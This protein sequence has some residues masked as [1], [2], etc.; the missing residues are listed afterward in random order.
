MTPKERQNARAVLMVRPAH[1]GYNEQTAVNNSFQTAAAA[2]A[3]TRI[4]TKALEEF[5]AF[6]A[7]LRSKA[8]EV[9]VVQDTDEPI[10]PDAV[11]PNNWFS[12]HENGTM[13]LYPMFAPNRRLE[14]RETDVID[15]LQKHHYAIPHVVDLATNSEANGRYLEGTGSLVLDRTH[16]IA[17]A[18]LSVRTD[19]A[20]VED[21]CNTIGYRKATYHAVDRAGAPIYHTNVV[22]CVGAS[23]VVICLEAIPNATE[24]T[25]LLAD[26]AATQKAVVA[27]TLEQLEHFA[28]NM[29]EVENADGVRF[30]VMSS[31]AYHALTAEQISTLEQHTQPL[32]A[33]ITTIETYGGGSARCMLAEVFL[34]KL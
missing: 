34:P 26:F 1:F 16:R 31:Q 32:H 3:Q 20:L 6:V 9:V 2:D 19:E 7:L 13:F 27:I 14:R 25:A 17:Y 15:T 11:F 8:I 33:D 12:T 4:A 29:L 23:V 10:K 28:G 22:M 18:C 30:L 21:Y 24:R 5:D